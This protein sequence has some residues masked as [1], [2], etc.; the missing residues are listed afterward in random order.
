MK[1]A[2]ELL[3]REAAGGR[4]ANK[5][6]GGTN[7]GIDPIRSDARPHIYIHTCCTYMLYIHATTS[8]QASMYPS[9]HPSHLLSI[10]CVPR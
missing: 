9:I 8:G 2:A 10:I 6:E 4:E 3:P 1:T 5:I 7:E